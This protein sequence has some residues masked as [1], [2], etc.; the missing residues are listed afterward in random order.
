MDDSVLRELEVL[1]FAGRAVDDPNWLQTCPVSVS[2]FGDAVAVAH[3]GRLALLSKDSGCSNGSAKFV[4][5]ALLSDGG[6]DEITSVLCLPVAD[7]A[8]KTRAHLIW[9]CV[10]VGRR[11][12][13]VEIITDSGEVLVRRR[14]LESPVVSLRSSAMTTLGDRIRGAVRVDVVPVVQDVLVVYSGT[15][16]T[17][18]G[19]QLFDTLNANL[20]RLAEARARGQEDLDALVANVFCKK[21]HVREQE[22]VYDACVLF[23]PNVTFD[24]VYHL[25]YGGGG[26]NDA[27]FKSLTTIM[28]VITVG[29]HPWL[30]YNL[31]YNLKHQ[32]INELAESVVSTVKSG[33]FRVAS[34]V[35]WGN[36]SK[37]E[38]P[39]QE[40][41][42]DP[43]QKLM[44]LHSF[45]DPTKEA[46]CLE[47]SPA[48]THLAVAD[49]QNRVLVIDA[50]SGVPIHVWKGYHHVQLGWLVVNSRP[51]PADVQDRYHSDN[52]TACLLVIYLARRGSLEIW[53]AERKLKIAEFA[54]AKNGRLI[55]AHNGILDGSGS[56][57]YSRRSPTCYFWSVD[58]HLMEIVI[59]YHSVMNESSATHDL[60]QQ[61]KLALALAESPEDGRLEEATE[62]ILSARTFTGRLSMLIDLLRW[63]EIS[64]DATKSV[65]ARLRDFSNDKDGD[66]TEPSLSD[67]FLERI[68][69]GVELFDFLESC[70]NDKLE[71]NGKDE[72]DMIKMLFGDE[73]VTNEFLQRLRE[74][75]GEVSKKSAELSLHEF[76]S[77]FDI[78]PEASEGSEM[79]QVNAGDTLKPEAALAIFCRLCVQTHVD[80]NDLLQKLSSLHISAMD[81]MCLSLKGLSVMDADTL[82]LLSPTFKSLFNAISTLEGQK[83]QASVGWQMQLASKLR[84][85]F[86]A[87]TPISVQLFFLLHEWCQF[88][89]VR[90][91]EVHMYASEARR[92]AG[93][94]A[95][96]LRISWHFKVLV[97][98]ANKEMPPMR[99][100][101]LDV[102][103][104]GNGRVTEIVSKW[105]AETGFTATRLFQ[106]PEVKT[107]LDKC[108]C[109]FPRSTQPRVIVA[110]LAWEL[111][112][113]WTQRLSDMFLLEE[114]VA[115]LEVLPSDFDSWLAHSIA[116]LAWKTFLAR[117]MRDAVSQTEIRSASRCLRQLG[118][119]QSELHRLLLSGARAARVLVETD[120]GG[121]G[122]KETDLYDNVTFDNRKKH[123]LDHAMTLR[124]S[125][126]YD[127][128]AMALQYQLTLVCC[129]IW[130][131]DVDAKPLGLFSTQEANSFFQSETSSALGL[132]STVGQGR[133]KRRVRFLK[134]AA[135]G[136][137]RTLQRL[138]NQ[139]LD[140]EEYR[141]W[142]SHLQLLAKMW[143]MS[144]DLRSA[145]TVALYQECHDS[146]GAESFGTSANQKSL[147]EEL[148]ITVALVRLTKYVYESGANHGA[149]VVQTKPYLMDK[150]TLL[151]EKAISSPQA[152][153]AATK[154]LLKLLCH[155]GMEKE[156]QTRTALDCLALATMF[157][158][159]EQ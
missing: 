98:T 7:S 83:C 58:G 150:M 16:V 145:L 95:A 135:R 141:S 147:A 115:F 25:S 85:L 71:W 134:H 124:A 107:F 24:R 47:K 8:K 11:S 114:A 69:R 110:H 64:S 126:A 23:Y 52:R 18:S 43:E 144:E 121:I 33:I 133:R 123:L 45:K 20:A 63:K 122:R 2:P 27:H 82:L 75:Q 54:V 131:L 130:R 49:N 128:E 91:D 97:K 96:F 66:H 94:C 57:R 67:I 93:C 159:E 28:Q 148:L 88:L 116:Q 113:R 104:E 36:S 56:S 137:V 72:G 103:E 60:V 112:H 68:S 1:L 42:R 38:K 157:Q 77:W 105:L 19:G 153:L 5:R 6:K 120:V 156:E 39:T 15:V 73:A 61:Q 46:V 154:D 30:Q 101:I 87:S 92:L 111:L 89:I 119:S 158:R 76:L 81:I 84:G 78:L 106:A 117:P 132:L 32:D 29:A 40:E 140:A 127:S 155:T 31:P 139:E 10:V 100:T 146:L 21:F 143:F 118:I 74:D 55:N 41:R 14:L 70:D 136:A 99:L 13:L 37:N 152:S 17:L 4:P 22:R 151:Q 12:G 125:P 129:L 90:E 149:K 48:N 79:L 35:L 138:P 3:R 86:T 109:H 102:F 34:G 26:I 51:P 108:A 59:P 50:L 80:Q 65:I 53:S 62:L 44:T 9:L 142:L